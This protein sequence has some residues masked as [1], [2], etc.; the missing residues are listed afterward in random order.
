MLAPT[1][2]RGIPQSEGF[3]GPPAG[4]G[5]V[6]VEMPT[7]SLGNGPTPEGMKVIEVC[8]IRRAVNL[9]VPPLAGE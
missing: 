3:H 5:A 8:D 1:A 4:Q 9:V 6:F 7:G 2:R